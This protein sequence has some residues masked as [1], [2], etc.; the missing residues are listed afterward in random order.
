MDPNIWG[1]HAWHFLHAITLTYPEKPTE[2]D[3]KNYSLFFHSL[4]NVLPCDKCKLN[5]RHHLIK[6]PLNHHILNSKMNLIT[7]LINIHN[8]VNK[9]NLK[10]IKTL[11]E[12]NNIFYDQYFYFHKSNKSIYFISIIAIIIILFILFKNK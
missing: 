8:E 3:K 6:Y 9:L 2:Q 12:I 10:P 5:F 7:W 1:P 11:D 4:K